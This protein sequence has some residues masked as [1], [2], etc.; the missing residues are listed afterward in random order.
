MLAQKGYLRLALYMGLGSSKKAERKFFLN[1][2]CVGE[3]ILQIL[4][5][6]SVLSETARDRGSTMIHTKRLLRLFWPSNLLF[7]PKLSMN[8]TMSQFCVHNY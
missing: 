6:G 4:G 7:I 5:E 8:F 2:P 3:V 1:S